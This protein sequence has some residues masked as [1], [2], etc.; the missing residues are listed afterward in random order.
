MR[1]QDKALSRLSASAGRASGASQ[2]VILSCLRRL[3]FAVYLF[4]YFHG[5]MVCLFL[6]TGILVYW[7][8]VSYFMRSGALGARD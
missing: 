3:Q 5:L 2:Q 6:N 1:Y 7:C 4:Y 8:S